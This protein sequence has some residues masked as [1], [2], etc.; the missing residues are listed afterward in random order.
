ML[1]DVL[2][3]NPANTP[4]YPLSTSEQQ[5]FDALCNLFNHDASMSL[6]SC[7]QLIRILCIGQC[8]YSAN[9]LDDLPFAENSKS[10]EHDNHQSRHMCVDEMREMEAGVGGLRRR[11]EENED[12]N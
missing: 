12:D 3:N 11:R 2:W 7:P 9:V 6:P 10:A 5:L 8:C 1:R 4:R